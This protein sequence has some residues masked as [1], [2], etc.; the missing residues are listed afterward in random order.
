MEKHNHISVELEAA[1]EIALMARSEIITEWLE[2]N[3]DLDDLIYT[4]AHEEADSLCIYTWDN[5][6]IL[7]SLEDA[8][9]VDDYT[10]L[11]TGEEDHER[12]TLVIA[13]TF[14][15]TEIASALQDLFENVEA[16]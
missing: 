8:G 16:A 13:Y 11:L 1:K 7:R 3:N 9:Q 5:M 4:R 15:N 12:R 2:G 6:M 14:W 10:E